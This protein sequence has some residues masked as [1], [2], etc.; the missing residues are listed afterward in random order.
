[1]RNGAEDFALEGIGLPQP[2]PLRCQPAVGGGQIL[3]ARGDALLES[4]VRALQLLVENDV[5]EGDGQPAA[6]DLD[7]RAVGAGETSRRLEHDDDFTAAH[8]PDVEDRAARGE[9][10]MAAGECLLDQLA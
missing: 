2:R 5:V 3:R 7:Q 1:V 4:R 8:R 6:E 9:L 10:V